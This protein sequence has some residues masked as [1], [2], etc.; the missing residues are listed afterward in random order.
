MDRW[1]PSWYSQGVLTA[2]VTEE[3][4]GG[5]CTR[6]R[7]G[8]LSRGGE[9]GSVHQGESWRRGGHLP[10]GGRARGV[11]PQ[12]FKVTPQRTQLSQGTTDIPSASSS[13]CG[14]VSVLLT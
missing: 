8:H 7:G 9:R 3:G 14:V 12:R 4:N 10:R 6:G 1:I 2:E 11:P 5:V 13:V